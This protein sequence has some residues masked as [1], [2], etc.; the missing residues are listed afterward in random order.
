M[1]EP[2][3]T[4]IGDVQYSVTPMSPIVASKLLTR[5]I[6]IVGEPIGKLAGMK[7]DGA[8]G[9][10]EQEI[11]GKLI[12][13]ALSV[14]TE[15]LDEN[16]MESILKRIISPEYVTFSTDGDQWKKLSS[17]DGHFSEHGGMAG[18]F[19]L[20]RFVLETNYS[21]FLKDLVG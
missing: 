3:K 13:E 8:K 16:E 15:K 21:D 6:K 20:A 12:S 1:R 17:I 11:D 18:M 2:Q 10:L 5:L 9:I 14:L 4:T 7:K 19:K